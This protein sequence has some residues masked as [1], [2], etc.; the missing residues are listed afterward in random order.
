MRSASKT[1]PDR[2]IRRPALTRFLS[3]G[4]RLT[5][6]GVVGRASGAVAG[7]QPQAV[8]G[9]VSGAVLVAVAGDQV[10]LTRQVVGT[11]A[12]VR[13]A[14]TDNRCI[15]VRADLV[16]S[17]IGQE[18]VGGGSRRREHRC[19]RNCGTST[20]RSN[21]PKFTPLGGTDCPRRDPRLTRFSWRRRR[22]VRSRTGSR[23]L[24]RHPD[25]PREQI[26]R[27]VGR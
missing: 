26:P 8:L 4:G 12:L 11:W 6:P 23:D 21:S 13:V 24:R 15:S 19:D 14:G 2:S 5:S 1:S 27:G 20:W 3:P 7:K 22:P 25:R 16:A 9:G 17:A 18:E 10:E